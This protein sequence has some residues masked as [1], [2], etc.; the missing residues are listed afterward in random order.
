MDSSPS[1]I[2]AFVEKAYS[3][4]L[5]ADKT[6]YSIDINKCRKNILHFGEFDYCVF[7]VSD[8]VDE[9]KGTKIRPGL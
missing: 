8:K 9:F 7:T 3:K 5:E 1:Q 6:I 2:H 4:E